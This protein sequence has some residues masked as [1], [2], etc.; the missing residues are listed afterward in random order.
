MTGKR[1]IL[2]T[3]ALPYANGSI[4]LGHM[5]EHFLV[6][7]WARYLK[8][9]GHDCQLICAADTHGAPIMMN[10]QAH[11]MEP[12]DFVEKHRKEQMLDFEG[13][14]VSYDNYSSTNT[15]L[16]RELAAEIFLALESQGHIVKKSIQQAYCEHDKMFLPDRFVKGTCPKCK[17]P[18]QYGDGCEVCGTVYSASELLLPACSLCGREPIEKDTEHL[19]IKLEDFRSF[20]QQWVPEHTHVAI[21]NKLQEWLKS[22]LQTWCISRDEPYFGFEIPGHAKKYYYVWFDAP[23]GYMSSFKEWCSKNGRDFK[24]EWNDSDREIYHVIGKDIVYHHTLFW[25]SMLKGAGY[26]TP[27]AVKVH[28]MLNVNGEKMSKSRG[29]FVQARTYLKHLESSYMRYYLACK[30]SSSIDDLDLN[31][32]DFVARVNS[33]LI[34][35][36]TNVASRGAQMLAKLDSCMGS[37]DEEGLELV[38]KAQQLSSE[39]SQHFEQTDFSKAMLLIRTI[40]DDANRYFDSYE[41]WKL[42]KVDEEK[43]KVVLTTILNLFRIMSVYLKPILPSYVEKVE[44][45]FGEGSYQW[46]DSQTILENHEIKPFKHLLKRVDPKKVEAIRKETQ[47][48]LAPKTTKESKKSNP[49]K[50]EEVSPEIGIEDFLKVD[51]RVAKII[52]ASEVEG[53]KKLLKLM[54]DIGEEKP[55]QVFSGIKSSYQAEDLIGRLTVMVANLAPRKMKFG[56]SEGMVL[57]AGDGKGIYILSPD[58]GAEPGQRIT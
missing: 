31:L 15:E 29:T 23:I 7:F 48:L 35:K 25:P 10:A 50:K 19:F 9:R 41:P 13:F 4:H 53:A 20:L 16:N 37:L 18:N 12:A 1:K 57:A 32:D 43:T 3:A 52:E 30:I 55:R 11:G 46:D 14:E 38:K 58:N 21:Q 28:G 2:I 51:L 17:A 5:V 42:I 22:E 33:D 34:G 39:I 47:E 44:A 8:M 36:I 27:K 6:D 56:L 45:L 54:L 26:Q 24:T 49:S 40:A